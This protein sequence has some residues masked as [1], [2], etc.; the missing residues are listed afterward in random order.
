M[1]LAHGTPPSSLSLQRMGSNERRSS[2]QYPSRSDAVS[3]FM[4]ESQIVEIGERGIIGVL[5]RGTVGE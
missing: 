2:P 5:R 1:G 4:G 3:S